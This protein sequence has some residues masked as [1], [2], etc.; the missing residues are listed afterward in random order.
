MSEQDLRDSMREALWDEPPLN[1]DPDSFME[2]AEQLTRRR[3]ALA[4]VGVVTA[5]LIATVATLPAVIM[6]N[7]PR[8][9]TAT[10]SEAA[11]P[12]PTKELATMKW[13][14]NDTPR[15][16]HVFAEVQPQL[17]VVWQDFIS[18]ALQRTGVSADSIGTWSPD[19]Q[20]SSYA[21]DNSVADVLRGA[22]VYT[23]H[24]GLSQL[25]VTIAGPGA[26]D[27]APDELCLRFFSSSSNC[28]STSQGD[29]SV[30]V[31]G[32]YLREVRDKKVPYDRSVF[33]YRPDGSVVMM[34][35]SNAASGPEVKDDTTD[36]VPLSVDELKQLAT[37]RGI[38]LNPS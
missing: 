32:E 25:D 37:N 5:L 31:V 8:V 1:F 35:S 21:R 4:S 20:G 27:P 12:S 9:D 22:V 6:A 14:P 15:Q 30:V 11:P 18:P 3:R 38:T 23:G 28:T 34:K 17:L 10:S 19:F 7:K 24:A 2:R 29:G 13:P 33:H 16:N 36:R 26:W